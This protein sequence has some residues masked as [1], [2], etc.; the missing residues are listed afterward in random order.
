MD[1]FW[2]PPHILMYL[3]LTSLGVW[4]AIVLLRHQKDPTVLDMSLIPRGYG[5][6]VVALPLAAIAG[7]ADFIWHSA[8]GFENQIDSTYS[9]PH[10][11]LFIAGALL[12]AIPAASAWK[13]RGTAPSLRE[14]LPA[15][16]VGHARS[17]A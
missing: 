17:P 16:F 4:I 13:R 3:G 6:A 8:Y 11:G 10:Q 14:F 1:T 12:A 15:V 2:S 9:P 7:P 5:L